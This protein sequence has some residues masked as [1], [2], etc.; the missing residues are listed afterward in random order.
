MYLFLPA[1]LH[2]N[3]MEILQFT[4]SVSSSDV[5]DTLWGEYAIMDKETGI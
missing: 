1:T 2:R 4:N 5:A 3:V